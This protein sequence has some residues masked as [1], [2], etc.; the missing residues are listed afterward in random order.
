MKQ[1]PNILPKN[2]IL[3]TM[4]V[5]SLYTNIPNKEGIQAIQSFL[6]N[7]DKSYLKPVISA[8]LGLILTLN[9][10]TFN[11]TNY[12]Q[13]NG[14]SMGTKCAPSYAN[15]FMGQFEIQHI[16]PRIREKALIYTRYID[17]I[18][19]IWTGSEPELINIFQE[20]NNIHPTIKFD[21]NYSTAKINFLDTLVV[22][23][24]EGKIRTTI[25]KKPTDEQAFLHQKSYHPPATKKSIAYSQALRIRRICSEDDDYDKESKILSQKLVDRGYPHHS[26]YE[27]ITKVKGMQREETLVY[28]EK[29]K[30]HKIPF[31]T[32]YNKHTPDIKNIIDTCWDTLKVNKNI[33]GKFTEKPIL[34]FRRNMNLKDLIGQTKLIN[35]KV[36][37]N[38]TK[39]IGKC[40]PCLTRTINKCCKNIQSTSVFKNRLL[41]SRM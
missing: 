26:V 8:F 16:L 17:D 24:E 31:I 18:F 35:N 39:Q 22:L 3:V 9:N 1:L 34:S 38:S 20:L 29:E 4:D 13:V 6:S 37:R 15:L 36:V 14:V 7:S 2:T 40:S 10:F 28:K 25:Y 32:T 27:Y 19:F 23:T 41:L 12:L 11:G 30:Q 33:V 21:T 5:R